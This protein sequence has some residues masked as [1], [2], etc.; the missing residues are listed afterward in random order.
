MLLLT[1]LVGQHI[2]S[3][4]RPPANR[5]GEI[6]PKQ[7]HAPVIGR[8]RYAAKSCPYFQQVF[9]QLGLS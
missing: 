9:L 4:D 3:S 7:A 8:G 1:V 2:V 6:T 5:Y